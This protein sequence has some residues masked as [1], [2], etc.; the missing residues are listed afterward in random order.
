LLL[1]AL[2]LAKLSTLAILHRIFVRDQ[3]SLKLLCTSAFG[4]ILT[5]GIGSILISAV[6]CPSSGFFVDHCSG[7]VS[8]RALA[9]TAYSLKRNCRS[10]DGDHY[11]SRCRN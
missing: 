1:A 9:W 11:R 4:I 3:A 7:Q 8:S 10:R 5:S 6:A 2:Y